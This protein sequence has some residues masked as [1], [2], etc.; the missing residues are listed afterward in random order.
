MAVLAPV[1]V[2]TFVWVEVLEV[3][4]ACEDFLVRLDF[5][6]ALTACQSMAVTVPS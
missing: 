4:V 1:L 6:V 2:L 5:L 3:M